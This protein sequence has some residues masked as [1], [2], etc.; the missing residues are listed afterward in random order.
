MSHTTTLK[1]VD[2]K[3]VSAIRSAVN[4]LRAKGINVELVENAT[5]RMY[6]D[7]QAADVGQC[8]FVLKLSNSPYD[9]GLK[10]NADGKYEAVF[11]EWANKVGGQIGASCP[12]P[13]TPEGRA[14]HAIGQFL[15]EYAKE[16]ATNAAV[17]QGYQVEDTTIDDDGTVHLTI[18]GV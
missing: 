5:P 15:Q 4:N 10:K 9:V 18:G 2:I 13:N 1:G 3:D 7:H 6:Y 16:A 17:S 14:Q 12:M 8:D 11:D